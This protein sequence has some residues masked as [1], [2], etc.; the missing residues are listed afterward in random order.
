M[1]KLRRQGLLLAMLASAGC[2]APH[3]RLTY[4]ELHSEAEQRDLRYGVFTPTGWDR[5]TPL[6]LV[7]LLHGRGDDETSADRQVVMDGLE[8]AIASGRV[9][10]FVMVTPRGER[11]FWANWYDGTYHWKDWV[12][13][14][15]VPHVYASYPL[16]EPA[17]GMHLVGV[18]MGGGGG[19]QMWLSDPRRFASASLLSA[20]MLDEADSRAMLRRFASPRIVDRVFGPPGAG[21]GHDPYAVLR[22]PADLGGSRLLFGAAQGDIPVML[23]SNRQL[24]AHLQRLQVPHD[25][26]EFPGK[27]GWNAWSTAIPYALCVQLQ[28]HCAESP[29]W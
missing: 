27:H 5:D 11:G 23:A 6:P 26:L 2:R 12:L 29:P 15:V 16:I 19:M 3:G 20:P 25:Y 1:S 14:E 17:E 24:H 9:P 4:V 21:G 18:S 10:P 7:V 22:T 13:E 8:E 28:A